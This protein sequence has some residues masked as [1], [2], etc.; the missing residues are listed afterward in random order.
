MN[1]RYDKIKFAVIM[2]L[3]KYKILLSYKKYFYFNMIFYS[4]YLLVILLLVL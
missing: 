3:E 4:L 1:F 2:G